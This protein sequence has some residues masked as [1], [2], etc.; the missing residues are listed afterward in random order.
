MPEKTMTTALPLGRSTGHRRRLTPTRTLCQ[1]ADQ[2]A[3]RQERERR[4]TA[5]ALEGA[6]ATINSLLSM[7]DLFGGMGGQAS[8]A[9]QQSGTGA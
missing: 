6:I 5:S 2:R 4:A 8:R 1:A 9:S 3:A 7:G